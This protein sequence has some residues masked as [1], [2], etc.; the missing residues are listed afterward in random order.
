MDLSVFFIYTLLSF[1][2]GFEVIDTSIDADSGH[3]FM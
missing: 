2:K 3:D 1:T